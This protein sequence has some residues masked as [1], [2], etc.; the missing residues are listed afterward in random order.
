MAS[1]LDAIS[2]TAAAKPSRMSEDEFVAWVF[3]EDVRAE[4][5]D[6][7]VVLMSPASVRHIEIGDWLM[8]LLWRY[9][10]AKKL[11]KV[12]GHDLMVRMQHP[13]AIRRIPDIAFISQANLTSLFTTYFEGAP[14]LVI[15]IVSPD[16]VARD[17]RDKFLEYEAAGVLE[18]WIIDPISQTVEVSVRDTSGKLK[19]IDLA[20]DGALHSATI[21]GFW[22]KIE[23]FWIPDF[24]DP[25]VHL[26]ALGLG[27]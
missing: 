17:W 19:K 13:R 20:T 16:S 12:F 1:A 18:Y 21:P 8:Q 14:D 10:R 7:E 9:V 5:V 15:E 27:L 4:W 24:I 26:R 2:I 11:G 25:D 22:L 3:A 6:G 23:W